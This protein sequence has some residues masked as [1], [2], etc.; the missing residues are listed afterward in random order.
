MFV[1]CL[2]LN[3]MFQDN[4]IC[5]SKYTLISFL[6]KNLFEQF[7]RLANIYFLF[8]IIIMVSTCDGNKIL[9]FKCN[10]I[11]TIIYVWNRDVSF[12]Y[13]EHTSV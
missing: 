4:Y 1:I 9:M 8:Q 11:K 5:T 6:P 12:R 10:L 13:N 7:H 3:I 2:Y